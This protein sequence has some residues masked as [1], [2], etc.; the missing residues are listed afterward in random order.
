MLLRS[1]QQRAALLQQASAMPAAPHR[2]PAAAPSATCRC[3]QR[4]PAAAAGLA[5]WQQQPSTDCHHHHHHHGGNEQ[6]QQQQQQQRCSWRRRRLSTHVC[7]VAAG[8]STGQTTSQQ[9]Q[10]VPLGS[11]RAQDVL[12][13]AGV[14]DGAEVYLEVL[15][16]P[17]G[18]PHSSSSSSS[19]AQLVVAYHGMRCTL[20]PVAAAGAAGAR[21][22]AGGA[23]A[24]AGGAAQPGGG[25][26]QLAPTGWLL[27]PDSP[28]VKALPGWPAAVAR[29][30]AADAPR[31]AQL[32]AAPLLL[33]SLAKA[34]SARELQAAVQANAAPWRDGTGVCRACVC[35]CVGVQC[36]LAVCSRVSL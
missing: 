6:Q 2:Q 31:L 1:T 26:W 28:L 5:S 22:G 15:Q 18:G 35:A 12:R 11:L 24:A 36:G 23:A 20:A 27:Q 13:A 25:V 9:Q 34:S 17:C 32:R 21:A 3:R 30:Q 4:A 19:D 7:A 29:Q 33:A 8:S 10:Q 14:Q 16:A